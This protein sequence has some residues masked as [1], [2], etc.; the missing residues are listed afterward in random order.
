MERRK[1]EAKSVVVNEKKNMKNILFTQRKFFLFLYLLGVYFTVYFFYIHYYHMLT[2]EIAAIPGTTPFSRLFWVSSIERW[3]SFFLES[4]F[5]TFIIKFLVYSYYI[6]QKQKKSLWD[7]KK[8]LVIL[9]FV[10]ALVNLV[11]FPLLWILID[12]PVIIPFPQNVVP[13][14]I[15][16][17]VAV[18]CLEAALIAM[19]YRELF[20]K[21][22]REW[23]IVCLIAFV[24]SFYFNR[25]FIPDKYGVGYYVRADFRTLDVSLKSYYIDHNVYPDCLEQLTTPRV[26]LSSIPRDLYDPHKRS[27]CYYIKEDF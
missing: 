1:Y 15:G 2:G 23:I 25:K 10:T 19:F 3:K 17:V 13:F 8:E 7:L 18:S 6:W 14:V 26:Y 5:R 16:V 20:T 9:F 22:T 4:W 21:K 11:T 24:V 27:F 12:K